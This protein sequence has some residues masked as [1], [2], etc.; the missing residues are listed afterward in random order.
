MTTSI[1]QATVFTHR[2]GV[3]THREKAPGR[4]SFGR[5]LGLFTLLCSLLWLPSQ[6]AL[7]EPEAVTAA[8]V[9]INVADAETLATALTGVGPARAEDI[10]RYRDQYGPF[11]T[12][13]QL[14]EVKGIGDATI[15][16][17]RSRITLE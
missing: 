17:N 15:E 1:N 12:V 8:V 11:T 6:G 14:A 10:V 16:R 3:F 13:E 7:A 4:H 5:L 2:N 9:N